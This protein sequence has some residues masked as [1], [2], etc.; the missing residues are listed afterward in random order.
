MVEHIVERHWSLKQVCFC[1]LLGA[2]DREEKCVTG[3]EHTGGFRLN[4]LARQR[5]TNE[6][7][8][9]VV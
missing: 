3:G 7:Q 4:R 5:Q 2:D 1:G 6:L 9:S 8:S